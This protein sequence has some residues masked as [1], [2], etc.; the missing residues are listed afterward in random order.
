MALSKMTFWNILHTSH[1]IIA[2][3]ILFTHS[4]YVIV[5]F[6]NLMQSY[7]GHGVHMEAISFDHLDT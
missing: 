3:S 6:W 4:N 7:E 5:S 2:W 1:T